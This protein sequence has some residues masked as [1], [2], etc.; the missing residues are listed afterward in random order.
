MA[1]V[2]PLFSGS[3]GNCTVIGDGSG[4]ILIDAG[5]SAKRITDALTE[6]AISASSIN[7]IFI[8]HEHSDHIGALRVF[9]G[10]RGIPVYASLRTLE[11]IKKTGQLE[12]VDAREMPQGGVTAGGIFVRSFPTMHDTA[13]SCG[14][15]AET[16]DGRK[17][18]VSTDLGIMTD[19]VRTALTGCD[20]VLIESNH[21]LDMLRFGPY[22]YALK[23]RIMSPCGHLSNDDCARELPRLAK[24]GTTRFVLGHLSEENNT[25]ELALSASRSA[26]VSAG[27]IENLDFTLSAASPSGT[28]L[29]LF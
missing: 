1:R 14:Y 29:L 16:S 28:P 5:T 23:Q 3:K 11:G 27:L 25:P 20:Y 22:S 8:T 15:T 19:D 13:G 17:I 9:A 4:Y 12:G 21:D 6:R 7:A 26:L 24:T 18:A 10:K 2:C